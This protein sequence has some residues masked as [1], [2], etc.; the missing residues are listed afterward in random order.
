M[1]KTPHYKEYLQILEEELLLDWRLSDGPELLVDAYREMT[2]E[3]KKNARV[4]SAKVI[5]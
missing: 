2:E 4:F 1:Q 5:F 3:G